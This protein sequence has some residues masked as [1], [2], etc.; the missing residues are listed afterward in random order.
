V[1]ASEV[2]DGRPDQRSFGAI[3]ITV[4]R[5]GYGR[6]RESFEVALAVDGLRGG[7]FPGVFIRAPVIERAGAGVE[8]LARVD[9]VPVLGRQ[10][11]IWFSSFHPELAGDLRLHQR[12]IS[13]GG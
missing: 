8:V 13:E 9:D 6:Q 4:R 12:F 10:G 3:D 2:V 7:P 1:C 11:P 5:N